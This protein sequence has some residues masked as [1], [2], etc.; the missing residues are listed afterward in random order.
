MEWTLFKYNYLAGV[1]RAFGDSKRPFYFL[2]ISS[3]INVVLDFVLILIIPMGV[4]GAALATVISQAISIVLCAWWLFKKMDMIQKTD[5]V[6]K[7]YMNLS[8][9]HLKTACVIGI[10]L[11]LEYSVTSIGNV[12]LQSSINS[13]GT[14]VAVAQICG[15]RIRAI[16]TMPMENVGMAMA[17]CVSALMAWGL[18]VIPCVILYIYYMQKELRKI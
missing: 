13:L 5:E 12:V 7:T 10:P 6:G 1:L 9:K 17:T 8:Q 2:L 14:V 11:G 15:E 3:A 16:A 4:A 18:A